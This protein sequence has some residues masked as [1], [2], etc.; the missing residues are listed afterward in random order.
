MWALNI[1]IYIFFHQLED[2]RSAQ[3]LPNLPPPRALWT[4]WV[5]VPRRRANGALPADLQRG[6]GGVHGAGEAAVLGD[7]GQRHHAVVVGDQD[8]VDGGQVHQLPLGGGC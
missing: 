6:L 7:V 4:M 2:S 5:G 8:D 3:N 1:Y